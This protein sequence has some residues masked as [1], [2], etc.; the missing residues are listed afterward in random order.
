MKLSEVL[1]GKEAWCQGAPVT[2]DGRICLMEA[3]YR[4]TQ[5]EDDGPH[6]ESPFSRGG[7]RL[8][9]IIGTGLIGVWNDS[10]TWEEVAAVIEEYDRLTLLE[11]RP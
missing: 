7:E 11:E 2:K 3:V 4:V 8:S 6:G 1:W 9:R 5:D 10:H